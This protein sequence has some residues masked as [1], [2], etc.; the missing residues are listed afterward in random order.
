MLIYQL[1]VKK[2]NCLFIII[3]VQYIQKLY[4]QKY[5]NQHST[6]KVLLIY[7]SHSFV[8]SLTIF[9]RFTDSYQRCVG[10]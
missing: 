9:E 5:F 4:W 2:Y 8:K 1:S 6:L 7:N 10:Y 3:F